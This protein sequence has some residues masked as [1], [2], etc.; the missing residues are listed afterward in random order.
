[1]TTSP[2][3]RRMILGLAAWSAIPFAGLH[4]QPKAGP[5]APSLN[6]SSPLGVQRGTSLEITL[7]GKNLAEPTGVW[8]SCPGQAVIPTESTEHACGELLRLGTDVEVV[9]PPELRVAMATT[10]CRCMTYYRVHAAIKGAAE[11]ARA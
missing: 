3:F 1:M 6:V 9:A 2:A 8:L 11:Q 5:Q 4:A 10:L 7:T